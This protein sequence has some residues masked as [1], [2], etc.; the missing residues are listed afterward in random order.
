MQSHMAE[1]EN[2]AIVQWKHGSTGKPGLIVILVG[3]I[4]VETVFVF[5]FK[6]KK[7][8]C[9]QDHIFDLKFN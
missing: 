6:L 8:K 3:V 2:A 1:L 9:E 4:S 5:L 7:E